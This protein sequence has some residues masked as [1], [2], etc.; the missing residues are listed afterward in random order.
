MPRMRT[1]P[2]RRSSAHTLR[3]LRSSRFSVVHRAGEVHVQRVLPGARPEISRVVSARQ[4]QRPSDR[5]HP[6]AG[7]VS[8]A[9]FLNSP[10]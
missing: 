8:C 3:A 4:D 2:G 9:R 5:P 1:G 7:K 6:L 10:L